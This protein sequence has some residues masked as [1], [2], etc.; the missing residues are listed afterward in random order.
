V[1]RVATRIGVLHEGRLLLEEDL[2]RLREGSCQVLV[3]LDGGMKIDEDELRRKLPG[4]IQ[5]ARRDARDKA[6]SLLT[7]DGRS[8]GTLPCDT[9]ATCGHPSSS[10]TSGRP[11]LL[12][13]KALQDRASSARPIFSG[14]SRSSE[15][16]LQPQQAERLLG[17]P[18]AVAQ[19]GRDVRRSGLPQ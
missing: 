13:E 5:A 11:I 2:D 4:C 19:R 9:A 14:L 1:E 3:E 16:Q 10:G 17:M 15:R 12:S 8:G 6:K 7:A 18:G